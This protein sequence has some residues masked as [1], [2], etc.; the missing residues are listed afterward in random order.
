MSIDARISVKRLSRRIPILVF[1]TMALPLSGCVFAELRDELKKTH[2]GL[3]QTNAQLQITGHEIHRA[4][5]LLG[6]RAVPAIQSSSSTILDAKDGIAGASKL[7]EPMREMR[8]EM[9][10]MR[11]DL[12]AL[13]KELAEAAVLVPALRQ[14]GALREPMLRVSELRGSMEQV[15]ALREPLSSLQ[16]LSE[17]LKSAAAL[18]EPLNATGQLVAPMKTLAEQSQRLPETGERLM[19][20]I[21]V[22]ALLGLLAWTLTT[23]FGVWLGSRLAR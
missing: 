8:E 19:S 13:K 2:Q 1:V 17:P 4:N 15:A 23:V 7:V 5:A 16:T 22:Y 12:I 10:A 21:W 11:G 3:H 6:D 9:Q 20:S 18:R 14:V